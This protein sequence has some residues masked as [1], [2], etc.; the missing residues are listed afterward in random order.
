LAAGARPAVDTPGVSEEIGDPLIS[1]EDRMAIGNRLSQALQPSESAQESAGGTTIPCKVASVVWDDAQRRFQRYSTLVYVLALL[2]LAAIL[3]AVV[4]FFV[5]D[6][7]T[8]AG[9][10]SL[11]S[12]LI[13]GGLGAFIKRERD[14]AAKDRDAAH[15]IVN[16]QCAG[17]TAEAVIATLG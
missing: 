10:V 12:G 8:G 5:S 2:A 6:D 15:K 3:L 4:F 13:S 14:A 9:L 16:E 11:V 7:G 1:R 17:Q